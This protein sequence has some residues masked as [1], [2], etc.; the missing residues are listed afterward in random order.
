MDLVAPGRGDPRALEPLRAQ[1]RAERFRGALERGRIVGQAQED[2]SAD[3]T[4]VHAVESVVAAIEVAV[5]VH[6][7][8]R[9]ELAVARVGPLVIRAD[10]PRHVTGLGL[11][12]LHAAMATRVVQRVDPLVVAAD[13]DDRVGVDVEGEV[14]PRALDL[15]RVSGEEPAAAPD[16]LE[17]EL[18]DP[19]VGLELALE[20][21]AGLVLDDQTVEQRSSVREPGGRQ[22][23][24]RH[25][26]LI[27]GGL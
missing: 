17:V 10:D 2:Q 22:E 8:A 19:R 26:L 16:A 7:T 5:L 4:G 9:H 14:V 23:R 25:R 24:I 11:A 12:D 21:V 15:A 1:E 27:I 6:P 3:F 13:D 18:V 20:S